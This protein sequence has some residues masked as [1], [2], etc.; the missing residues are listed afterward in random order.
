M[1]SMSL[2]LELTAII[3][4]LGDDEGEVLLE[5]A[6]RLLKGKHQY[7]KLDLVN[8]TRDFE[9][10]AHEELADEAAYRLMESV[11]RRKLAPLGV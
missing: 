3:G 6:K 4:E 7:G 10:E 9:R 8:D 5:L 2:A 11:R 1:T